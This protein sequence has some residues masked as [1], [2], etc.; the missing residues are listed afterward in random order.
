MSQKQVEVESGAG[1][2]VLTNQRGAFTPSFDLG[3]SVRLVGLVS[4]SRTV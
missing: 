2:A 3:D 4:L 1:G